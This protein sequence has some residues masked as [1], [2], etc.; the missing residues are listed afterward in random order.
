METDNVDAEAENVKI[1]AENVKIEAENVKIEADNVKIETDSIKMEDE[2]VKTEPDNIKTEAVKVKTEV[3][4]VKTEVKEVKAEYE[5]EVT[6]MDFD[7]NVTST[8]AENG[9][10][11]NGGT[12]NEAPLPLRMTLR[13]RSVAAF[14]SLKSKPVDGL[15]KFE[16]SDAEPVRFC[17]ASA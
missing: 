6:D 10:A 11:E 16:T 7:P 8:A 13:E 17:A 5:E 4:D 9:N 15:G 1:E 2:N 12:T 3:K 14:Q